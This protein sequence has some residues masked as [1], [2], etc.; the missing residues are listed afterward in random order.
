MNHADLD[1]HD[2]LAAAARRTAHADIDDDAT[3]I[4]GRGPLT[5]GARPPLVHLIATAS[6]LAVTVACVLLFLGAWADS[7]PLV[8]AGG[9]TFLAAL[10]TIVVITFVCDRD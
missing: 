9:L 5:P 7:A 1:A 3:P 2:A 10:L 8:I 6:V 4:R